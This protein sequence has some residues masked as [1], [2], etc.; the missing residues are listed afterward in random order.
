MLPT[1]IPVFIFFAVLA[2]LLNW[3]PRKPAPKPR[4]YT[5]GPRVRKQ[6]ARVR[7]GQEN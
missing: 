3:S 7:E 1:L 4:A 5:T 6:A 2:G